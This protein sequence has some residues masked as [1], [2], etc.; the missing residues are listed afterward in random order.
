M[1]FNLSQ[2]LRYVIDTFFYNFQYDEKKNF[3]L[4]NFTYNFLGLLPSILSLKY[5]AFIPFLSKFYNTFY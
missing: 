5:S 1:S 3:I 4:T 2:M